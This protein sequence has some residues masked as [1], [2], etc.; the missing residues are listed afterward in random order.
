M[1]IVALDPGIINTDMAV[2]YFGDLAS[3]YQSPQEW[4]A[5][6]ILYIFNQ[7]L[8]KVNEY[9]IFYYIPTYRLV[10]YRKYGEN[11]KTQW[12]VYYW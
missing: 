3:Q 4:Y 7:H 5:Y 1:T 10:T 9:Y 2:V 8:V 11:T 12:V 6:Q